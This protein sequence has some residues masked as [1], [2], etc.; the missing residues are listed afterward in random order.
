[1]CGSSPKAVKGVLRY[2]EIASIN[3]PFSSSSAPKKKDE[4]RR[5]SRDFLQANGRA[6]EF[7][8][9]RERGFKRIF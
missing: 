2:R 6:D 8:A 3:L 9:L 7:R 5:E 4:P 1:M